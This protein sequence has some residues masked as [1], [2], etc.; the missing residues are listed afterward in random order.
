LIKVTVY[1]T[2]TCPYCQMLKEYL[3][4]KSIPFL[5]RLV[6]QDETAKKEMAATS[7][8]FLGV[9]FIVIDKDGKTETVVGFDKGRLEKLLQAINTDGIYP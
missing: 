7:G 3:T 2:T 4:R 9:P 5:E 8:G 6:D 1:S